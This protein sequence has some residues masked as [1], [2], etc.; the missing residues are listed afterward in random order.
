MKKFLQICSLFTFVF[1]LSAVSAS[2]QSTYGSEVEIPFAFSVNDRSYEAGK[3]IVKVSKF[4]TGSAT[5]VITDPK[6]E[7]IQTVL[8][9]RNGES[10]DE[11][12]KLTFE[13]IEGQKV[14]S[15]VVTPSGGFGLRLNRQRRDVAENIVAK[16]ETVSIADI[17]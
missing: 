6:T 9:Q 14:L 11:S 16:P 7:S 2:A 13:T 3:Y 17:F 5:I 4:Q 15:R 10:S 8:A 1:V 12:V